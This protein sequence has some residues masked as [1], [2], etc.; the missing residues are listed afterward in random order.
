MPK[1]FVI[2]YLPSEH[3][4]HHLQLHE[5]GQNLPL[6]KLRLWTAEYYERLDPIMEGGKGVGE[7]RERKKERKRILQLIKS[8]LLRMINLW[9]MNLCC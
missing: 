7:E 9:L 3:C 8:P 5:R 2:A 1:I 6:C 4:T